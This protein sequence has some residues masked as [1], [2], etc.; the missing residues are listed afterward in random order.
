M[1]KK[2]ILNTCLIKVEGIIPI[3]K[4]TSIAE[5]Q[6]LELIYNV[7]QSLEQGHFRF[8]IDSLA[9]IEKIIEVLTFFF[10]QSNKCK[11][12][13]VNHIWYVRQLKGDLI[14]N[15]SDAFKRASVLSS[16]WLGHNGTRLLNLPP[17]INKN[18]PLESSDKFD[19]WF[20]HSIAKYTNAMTKY[21]GSCEIL[22]FEQLPSNIMTD[23][24]LNML[25]YYVFKEAE[26][27]AWYLY[28]YEFYGEIFNSEIATLSI[29]VEGY[30]FNIITEYW[31][32]RDFSSP[33]DSAK[34]VLNLLAETVNDVV[35][36][37][38]PN[39]MLELT[40]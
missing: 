19:E 4:T 32:Y 18:I 27:R 17:I 22:K 38:Y 1:K 10:S 2:E 33:L 9:L 11:V 24:E 30:L 23:L 39:Y 6:K 40:Q 21:F 3:V 34:K 7:L 31:N 8:C 28:D 5:N 37:K 36:G 12:Q 29:D 26:Y 15:L 13:K 25:I 35:D 14:F 16:E 20:D